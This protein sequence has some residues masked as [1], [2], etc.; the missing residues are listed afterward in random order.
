MNAEDRARYTQFS[1]VLGLC[2]VFLNLEKNSRSADLN[3]LKS[4]ELLDW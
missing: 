4:V 1:W 2:V 3:T